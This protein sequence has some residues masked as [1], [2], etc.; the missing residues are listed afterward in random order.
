M[1]RFDSIRVGDGEPLHCLHCAQG[2]PSAY[3]S[4]AAIAERIRAATAAWEGHPG[5]NVVLTGPD[6]FGHPELPALIAACAEAGAE[7]IALETDGGALGAYRNAEGVFRAGVRHLWLRVLAAGP[8]G[9]ELSGH[10][11]LGAS[12]K[13]GLRT[14]LDVADRDGA[15]A[16]VT[17]LVPV[18]CHNLAVLPATVAAL[19]SWG[20]HAVR[21]SSTSAPLPSSAAGV[22][23]AA[24]DT[25]MVNR[26]WVETDG[27]LPLPGSHRLHAVRDGA[28]ND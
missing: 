10:R 2:V 4:A 25:G 20:V 19:A 15:V 5:P 11:D 6:P 17:A 16:A 27:T 12:V 26:L 1:L 7:R 21:L 22:I 9:D 8:L 18:C 14:Y 28:C 23:A 13:A 3:H 24:C